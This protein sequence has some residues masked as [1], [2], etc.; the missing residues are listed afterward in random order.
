M[1]FPLLKIIITLSLLINCVS[2]KNVIQRNGYIHTDSTHIYDIDYDRYITETSKKPVIISVS[3]DIDTLNPYRAD[4]ESEITLLRALFS[5]L[6][7]INPKTGV[8]ERNLVLEDSF[9]INENKYTFTL[10]SI[11]FSNGTPLQSNDVIAS[12]SLLNSVLK[13]SRYYNNFYLLNTT[14]SVEKISDIKFT[15]T[16][17]EPN[18][19]LLYALSDF[20][21]IQEEDVKKIDDNIENFIKFGMLENIEEISGSGPFQIFKI[22][23]HANNKNIIL[24]KNIYYFKFDKHHVQLPYSEKIILKLYQGYNNKILSFTEGK[25]DLLA[26]GSN[27]YDNLWN[28]YNKTNVPPIRFINTKIGHEKLLLLYNTLPDSGK[29]YIKST[30]FRELLA[31]LFS[32]S[33]PHDTHNSYSVYD[34]KFDFNNFIEN[35]L[36]DTNNDGIM[37]FTDGNTIFLKFI[38]PEGNNNLETLSNNF[39]NAMK[40]FGFDIY[41]E[42]LPYHKFLER[43]F[44]NGDFDISLFYHTFSPGIIPYHSL[45]KNETLTFLPY[46]SVFNS[47][48]FI[49]ED[50]LKTCIK[51]TSIRKQIKKINRLQMFFIKNYQLIPVLE[52][53]KYYLATNNIYNIKLNAKFESGLNLE[54][55]EHIIKK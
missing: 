37:E 52:Q 22:I 4:N 51:E 44:Y 55:L 18:G 42:I 46:L 41:L 29:S 27:D 28:Y 20:P 48:N 7:T 25:S 13:N 31:A 33:V 14:L 49:F 21:I 15:I 16:T 12:L 6:F 19:N 54:T 10:K 23:T 53:K 24:K 2:C 43:I 8:P 34:K 1:K 32:Q 38:I 40:E 47:D 30:I 9:D 45:I 11:K 39:I 17:D 26:L 3:H 35:Y 50:E 5:S 36:K